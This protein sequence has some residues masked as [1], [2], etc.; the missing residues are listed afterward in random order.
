MNTVIPLNLLG[1]GL[2]ISNVMKVANS[3]TSFAAITK[4]SATVAHTVPQSISCT[5]NVVREN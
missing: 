4:S 3:N 1:F 2:M 5:L